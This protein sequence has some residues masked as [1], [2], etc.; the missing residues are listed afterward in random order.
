MGK[1]QGMTE[2]KK[3]EAVMSLIRKEETGTKI[4]RRYGVSEASLY[5]W[6]DDFLAGGKAALSGKKAADTEQTTRMLTKEIEERD[7]V[8][9]EL[10][11]ANRILKKIQDGSY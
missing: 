7:R 8:I 3:T 6:R 5:R 2:E 1:K 10:T 9:G 4:A 11:I